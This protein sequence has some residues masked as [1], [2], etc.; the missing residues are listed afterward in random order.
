LIKELPSDDNLPIMPKEIDP[1]LLTDEEL[2]N[3][4]NMD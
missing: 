4:L 2:E 3:I 1:D